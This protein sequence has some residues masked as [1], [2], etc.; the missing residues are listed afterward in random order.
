MSMG[1]GTVG[2]IVV[3]LV[4]PVWGGLVLILATPICFLTVSRAL[5]GSTTDP[6]WEWLLASL[7]IAW[8]ALLPVAP[9]VHASGLEPSPDEWTVL[10]CLG[11]VPLLAGLALALRAWYRS[12]SARP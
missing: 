2:A 9:I 12:R 1:F 7:G 5:L 6:A 3:A 10:I 4:G 8:L 11:A